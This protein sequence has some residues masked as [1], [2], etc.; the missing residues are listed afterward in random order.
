MTKLSINGVVIKTP[1]TFSVG[2]QTIDSDSTGRNA[3]GNMVRD[4]IAEKV[5]LDISWGPL[6]DNEISQILSKISG[7]FFSVTYPDPQVGG[8][9]TKRFYVGDRTAPS[10]SWNEHFQASKWEGLTLSFIEE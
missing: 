1:K 5:K 4:I 6:S 9:T 10:Y 7:A 8:N 3:S 2:I